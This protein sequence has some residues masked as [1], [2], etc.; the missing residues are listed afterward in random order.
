M[1]GSGLQYYKPNFKVLGVELP[2]AFDPDTQQIHFPVASACTAIGVDVRWQRPRLL[3]DFAEH[4]TRLR[5]PTQGGPQELLCI[6]YD[7]LGL[8]LATIQAERTS[9]RVRERIREF[10]RLVMAAASDI[11]AGKLK[12]VPLNERRRA[13]RGGVAEALQI[14]SR[15]SA[16]ERAVF[17]GE[18][19]GEGNSRTCPCPYC[20]RP[21]LV[22]VETVT[23]V[24]AVD[25]AE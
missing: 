25:D 17:V 23:V 5:L 12:P 20:G 15:L 21:L 22:N 24:A 4:V 2:A 3:R 18:P 16:V 1:G 14:E 13:A 6:S 10:R 9:E 7:A 11:L 8:W 19:T